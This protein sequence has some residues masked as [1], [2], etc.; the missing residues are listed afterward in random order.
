MK[1]KI[2][3]FRVKHEQEKKKKTNKNKNTPTDKMT[4]SNI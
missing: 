1:K 3:K 2:R 4:R